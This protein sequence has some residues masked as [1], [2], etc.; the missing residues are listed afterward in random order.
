MAHWKSHNQNLCL[1]QRGQLR[2][3]SCGPP[4]P[5]SCNCLFTYD[6]PTMRQWPGSNHRCPNWARSRAAAAASRSAHRNPHH[7]PH[8]PYA[9]Y[10]YCC[11]CYSD[12]DDG[13]GDV[14]ADG[15]AVAGA[16]CASFAV[17]CVAP[18]PS[19][20]CPLVRKHFGCSLP[21]VRA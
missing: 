2:S 9:V 16:C 14:V 18:D 15:A 5:F 21:P 17:Q 12:V 20:R 13:A 6:A 19:R 11:C 3:T 10:S 1:L 4:L 7:P 8:R